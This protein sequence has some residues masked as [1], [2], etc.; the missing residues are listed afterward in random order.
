MYRK[1]IENKTRKKLKSRTSWSLN[2]LELRKSSLQQANTWNRCRYIGPAQAQSE[3][4]A[5]GTLGIS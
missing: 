1:R 3:D 2:G 4:P 5:P